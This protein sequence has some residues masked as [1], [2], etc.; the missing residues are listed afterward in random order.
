MNEHVVAYPKESVLAAVSQFATP[1]F[2]YDEAR[3]RENCRNFREGFR[4]YFPDFAPLYAVKANSNPTILKIII[5]EGFGLDC[6]SKSEAWIAHE[7]KAP[8]MYT[9]NY[10][11]PEELAF[12]KEMGLTL[13]LDD[14]SMIG[15]LP[16]IGVPDLLSFRINPGT[17][18]SGPKS[19]IL[20]GP[21]AKYGIPF[22]RAIEAYVAAQKIGV[23]KF[24]IHMMTGFNILDEDYFATTVHALLEIIARVKKEIGI[25]ITFLNMGGGFGVPY[26]P[27]EKSLNIEKI[28]ASVRDVFNADCQR[29]DI[30]EPKLIAEP[31]RYIAADMGFLVSKVQVIKDGYKKFVGIDAAAN[32]MP[33]PSI[34]DAYH[35]IS[36]VTDASLDQEIVSIVG[37]ICENNDQFA[38]DRLLPRCEIGDIVVIHNC[39]G[40]AYSMGHNYN[41]LPRHAEHLISPNGSLRTI[42]EAE[43][44]EDLYRTTNI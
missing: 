15:F 41:G 23:K 25:E 19:D 9:G 10:T 40:H 13:N 44:I 29:L 11:P 22:E 3:L 26:R 21:D 20:A 5:S 39:G 8:G 14:L 35:H 6:S 28:A 24:G 17:A 16:N 31:G 42:R 32:D 12:A 27:E 43:K 1:F 4:K 34:Y 30:K 7:L 33:R 2:L 37:G 18:K 36:V 38:K